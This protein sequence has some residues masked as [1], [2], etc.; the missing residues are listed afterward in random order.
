MQYG[1]GGGTPW[2][3]G[4]ANSIVLSKIKDALGLSEAK[5]CFTAAAPIAP[6]TLNYFASLDIPVYEV[7]GQSECTG[8]H[9]VSAAKCWKIGACGRPIRGSESMIAPNTGEL[10]YRGRHIFMGYMYMPDKTAET[11]DE[12]GY[13]HSGDVAEFDDD[14]DEEIP[15]P[16]GFMRI[17]GRIKELI[18]TAGGENVPPVLIENE[19]KAAMNALSNVMVIGDKRKFLSM[20][21]SLKV[22]P[23]HE[24]G[25]PSDKL[26]ADSLFAGQN[27]GSSATTYTEAK[28]DPLWA[29][30]IDAGMKK[31]NSRTTSNAQ[32]VQK[33]KWLPVDFSEKAGDLTPTLKLKR[34]VVAEKY[35]DLLNSVYAGNCE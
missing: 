14:R 10:C 7:F 19:M 28:K 3:Y 2:G 24:S 33:W 9:T 4:C 5:A 11:I 21:V 16:S 23:D 8:P 18:I 29:A 6:E 13:L 35:A 17:T 12:D 1:N 31:A 32:I 25:L 30:Y 20:V 22:E 15:G 34:N 27:I 26:A